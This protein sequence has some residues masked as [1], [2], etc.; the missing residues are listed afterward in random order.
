[1]KIYLKKEEA[2][3]AV[4]MS[5]EIRVQRCAK[6]GMISCKQFILWANKSLLRKKRDK[7]GILNFQNLNFK[8]NKERIFGIQLLY[9]HFI[10]INFIY[11]FIY[12]LFSE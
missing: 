5:R 11:N 12:I 2:G 9:E 1:M 3:W 7:E 8:A 6:R 10:Y 4:E